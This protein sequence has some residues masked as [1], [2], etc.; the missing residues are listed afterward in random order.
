MVSEKMQTFSCLNTSMFFSSFQLRDKIR[1]KLL[2]K[3]TAVKCTF[4]ILKKKMI[5]ALVN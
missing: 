1:E 5:L 2:F 3:K 4:G